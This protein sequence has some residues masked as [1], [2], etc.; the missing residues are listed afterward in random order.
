MERSGRASR[1]PRLFDVDVDSAL[2][3]AV[4]RRLTHVGSSLQPARFVS[5][6]WISHQLL[7][8]FE[9]QLVVEWQAINSQLISYTEMINISNIVLH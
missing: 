8:C 7:T 4:A 9:V 1:T 6:A 5:A 3:L 2:H